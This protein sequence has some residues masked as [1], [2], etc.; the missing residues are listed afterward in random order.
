MKKYLVRRYRLVPSS[1]MV[2]ADSPLAAAEKAAKL[3]ERLF[4][5]L[6]DDLDSWPLG[7]FPLDVYENSEGI[8]GEFLGTMTKTSWKG[9]PAP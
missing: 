4:E 1:V 9:E 5:A 8:E 6:D 7:L 2:E 3:D